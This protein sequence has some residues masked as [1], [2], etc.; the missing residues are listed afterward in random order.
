MVAA[1]PGVDAGTVE[2]EVA[3][4]RAGVGEPRPVGAVG[5]AVAEATGEPAEVP[6]PEEGERHIFCQSA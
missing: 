5:T 6:A 3:G 1:V 4:A 2:A